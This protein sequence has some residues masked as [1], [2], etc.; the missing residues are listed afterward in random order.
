LDSPAIARRHAHAFLLSASLKS[1]ASDALHARIG[2]FLGFDTPP[3]ATPPW[4]DF[5]HWCDAT[6]ARLT[7]HGEALFAVLYGTPL[8]PDRTLFEGARDALS[9]IA[10]ERQAEWLALTQQEAGVAADNRPA[11]NAIRYQ[12]RRASEGYLL[13]ELAAEGFLPG[14]GFPTG[15]V[16]LVTDSAMRPSRIEQQ[17]EDSHARS[18]DYPSRQLDIALFEYAPGTTLVLDGLV[19]TSAGIT[20]NW[21]GPAKRRRGP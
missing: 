15:I 5:L 7:E 20:L 6:E 18:R 10:E 1:T 16:P 21:H 3:E 2:D 8:K 13:S 4:Q 17:R 14:Y 19:Y 12:K 11:L 9:R